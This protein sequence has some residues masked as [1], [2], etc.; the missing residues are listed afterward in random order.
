MFTYEYTHYGSIRR[1][2][3]DSIK[4]AVSCALRD[5]QPDRPFIW[6]RKISRG[7]CDIWVR[8]YPKENLKDLVDY[9]GIW[10]PPIHNELLESPLVDKHG[11]EEKW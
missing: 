11:Q 1:R 5:V 6:P 10:Y 3:V 4:Q 8:T 7:D 2:E 9:Y